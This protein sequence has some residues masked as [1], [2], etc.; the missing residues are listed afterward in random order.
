MTTIDTTG[1][2][3]L[4]PEH[5]AA[6]GSQVIV[7]TVGAATIIGRVTHHTRNGVWIENV[8]KIE[9]H[10]VAEVWRKRPPCPH[11]TL[12]REYDGT[13]ATVYFVCATDSHPECHEHFPVNTG[14]PA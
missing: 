10:L 6:A 13:R 14:Q 11:D 7:N 2:E 3:K 12:R 9:A 5:F 1:Y 4:D 8:G